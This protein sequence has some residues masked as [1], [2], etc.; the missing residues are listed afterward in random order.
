[1]FQPGA[2]PLTKRLLNL[3]YKV[4]IWTY[5][6]HSSLHRHDLTSELSCQRPGRHLMIRPCP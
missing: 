4:T 3:G 2:F 1:M 5:R 6:S